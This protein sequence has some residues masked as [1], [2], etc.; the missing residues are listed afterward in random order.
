[1]KIFK[2]NDCDWMAAVSLESAKA[3]YMED[4]ADGLPEGEAMEDPREVSEA[5]M[6]RLMFS[7]DDGTKMTFREQ[8]ARLESE[9]VKFPCFFA[10]TEY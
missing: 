4:H 3:K 7:E 8:L 2:M 9:R 6:D 1:M 10:S 5:D